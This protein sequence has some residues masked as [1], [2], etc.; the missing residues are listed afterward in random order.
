MM[1]TVA[2]RGFMNTTRTLTMT[3]IALLTTAAASGVGVVCAT[4]FDFPA[5]QT[6]AINEMR[7]PGRSATYASAPTTAELVKAHVSP[8]DIAAVDRV[9]STPTSRPS[10]ASKAERAAGDDSMAPK[11]TAGVPGRSGLARY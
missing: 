5:S 8:L 1:R 3:F 10:A 6:P 9:T 7:E 4:S 11:T 2:V